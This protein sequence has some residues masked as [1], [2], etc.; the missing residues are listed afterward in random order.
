MALL[1]A[2]LGCQALGG[3]LGAYSTYRS[4]KVQASLLK[5]QAKATLAT[6]ERNAA[7][8]NEQAGYQLRSLEEERVTNEANTRAAAAASGISQASQTVE[9]IQRRQTRDNAYQQWA[10]KKT[11]TDEVV[12]TLYEGRMSA[13][14]LSTQ[15]SLTLSSGKLSAIS[16][17]LGTGSNMTSTYLQYSG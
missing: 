2:A 15:A 4:S 8:I 1:G 9:E 14:G 5:S 13:A 12:N 6:A 3:L 17:L 7:K 16:Q 11:A 10:V